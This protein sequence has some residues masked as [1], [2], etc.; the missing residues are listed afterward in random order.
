MT[1]KRKLSNFDFSKAG[2]H[3]SLV[4]KSMGGP[5]N[6]RTT[7]LLK[8]LNP[9]GETQ[10]PNGEGNNVEMIEKSVHDTLVKKAVDDAVAVFKAELDA[11]KA[12]DATRVEKARKEKL[13]AVIGEAKLEETYAAI[14]SLDDAGF[15]IVLKS[16]EAAKTTEAGSKMFTEKGLAGKT[17][18]SKVNQEQEE[19]IEAKLLK[20]KFQTK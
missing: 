5:A 4:G 20:A 15:E 8:S 1:A 12:A 3:I 14:K 9:S 16:F 18:Q 6:G 10:L 7:L 11:L 19:S 2:C 17:D 13:V